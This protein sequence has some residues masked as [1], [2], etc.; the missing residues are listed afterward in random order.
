MYLWPFNADE[1]NNSLRKENPKILDVFDEIWNESTFPDGTLKG[2]AFEALAYTSA[3]E[4]SD[5][6]TGE[7]GIP[8]ICP[9]IGSNDIFSYTWNIPFRKVVLSVLEQ[10]INW[11][12]HTY[13]KIGNQITVNP[14][15]YE[16]ISTKNSDMNSKNIVNLYINITNLGISK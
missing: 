5:W 11:L 9:E 16:V 8:S 15:G 3:G 13:D 12:E 4:Q 2:N 1:G 10:N 6:I 7:L 14:L